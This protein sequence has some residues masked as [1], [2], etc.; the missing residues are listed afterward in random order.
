MGLICGVRKD[1]LVKFVSDGRPIPESTTQQPLNRSEL[2]IGIPTVFRSY[3]NYFLDSLNS[4]ISNL[5]PLDLQ[6]VGFIISISEPFRSWERENIT[7]E[8]QKNFQKYLDSDFSFSL[9]QIPK[10]SE[11]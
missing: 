8:L 5:E 4:L 11:A 10:Y 2:L 9:A 1:I 3:K 7:Q 6:R